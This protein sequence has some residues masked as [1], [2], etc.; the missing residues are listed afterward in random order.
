MK[1]L[2]SINFLLMFALRAP[3][4]MNYATNFTLT[5]KPI[6]ENGAWINGG[7]V[8]LDWNNVQAFG[9]YACGTQPVPDDT[10]YDDSTAV[11]AGDWGPDQ[12]VQATVIGGDTTRSAGEEIEL[13]V[14]TQIAPHWI[15]GYEID[16][17]NY[18]GGGYINIV[19]W[20]GA[21]SDFTQ[22][23][24]SLPNYQGIKTG[25]VIKATIVGNLITAYVN[26][27]IVSQ[28]SDQTFRGGS[29]GV[30]FDFWDGPALDQTN[31]GLTNF[32]ASDNGSAPTPTPIPT[33]SPSPAPT[34]R[35]HHHFP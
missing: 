29:P 28:A 16:F 34:P 30:G 15:T 11:L 19:R 24:T 4:V 23:S 10:S 17:R 14:R 9:G 3:A 25:D 8:G 18:S 32:S 35:H 1:L 7:Q 6:S 13:R 33:P 22:L 2:L 31:F 5:E 12:T 26:D 27:Q 21:F 20:N